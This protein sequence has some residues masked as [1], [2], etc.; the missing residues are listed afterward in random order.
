LCRLLGYVSPAPRTLVSAAGR[1]RLQDFTALSRVHADGWGAG[2]V[3]RPGEAVHVRKSTKAAARDAEFARHTRS[4]RAAAQIGHLRLASPGL[5]ITTDNTHPFLADG[6]AFAH[7]GSLLPAERIERLLDPHDKATLTGT[8]D[9]E[10]YFALVRQLRA[11]DPSAGLPEAVRMA[12][13]MLRA[14]FPCGSLNALVLD[15]E[16]LVVVHANPRS[17]APDDL[18]DLFEEAS[19]PLEHNE[20]YGVMRL[21]RDIDGGVLVSSTG[22]LSD[23]W[24]PLPAESVTTV[25]LSDLRVTTE[26]LPALTAGIATL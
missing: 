15:N 5:P 14:E 25:R 18:A 1:T 24:E 21:A 20:Q 17:L 4:L 6:V 22:V 9:S 16:N 3:E 7:N 11:S 13:A 12:A 19:L 10:R 8:T 26:E 23:D 2:W